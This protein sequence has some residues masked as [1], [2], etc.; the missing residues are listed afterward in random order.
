MLTEPIKPLLVNKQDA[1]MMLGI[2]Q[3][4]LNRL[5]QAGK[6]PVVNL[7]RKCQRIPVAAIKLLISEKGFVKA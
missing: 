1:A 3:T 7:G 5:I 4:G 2:G 6:L